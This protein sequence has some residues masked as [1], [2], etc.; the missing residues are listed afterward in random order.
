[1]RGPMQVTKTTQTNAHVQ[2]HIHTETKQSVRHMLLQL[3][4]CITCIDMKMLMSCALS[5]LLQ[6]NLV[7]RTINRKIAHPCP[8]Q[9]DPVHACTVQLPCCSHVVQK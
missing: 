5:V 3:L 1:M 7:I 4:Q 2:T 9:G 8:E 6:E